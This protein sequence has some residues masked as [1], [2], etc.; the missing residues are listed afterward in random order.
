MLKTISGQTDWMEI[1]EHPCFAPLSPIHENSSK[2]APRQI[3]LSIH[4]FHFLR[5]SFGLTQLFWRF[6]AFFGNFQKTSFTFYCL[7]NLQFRILCFSSTD[8]SQMEVWISLPVLTN[9][10]ELQSR[11]KTRF[12]LSVMPSTQ[13]YQYLKRVCQ[14]DILVINCFLNIPETEE[15]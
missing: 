6:P 12:K 14:L 15:R 5:L 11:L 4:S 2:M 8:I 9:L 1:S 10:P 7:T 13:I 3:L